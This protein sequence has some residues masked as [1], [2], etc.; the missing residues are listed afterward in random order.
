L[1]TTGQYQRIGESTEVA[2][3][4][5]VEKLGLPGYS[6]MPDA[7]TKLSRQERSSFCNDHWGRN[8]VR[9]SEEEF[10]RDRKM[11]SVLVK[12]R[13]DGQQAPTMLYLKVRTSHPHLPVMCCSL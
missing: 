12:Q 9:V 11:M 7:L 1:Y 3:R 13:E 6:P 4:V 2:L 10:S 8:M 5:L